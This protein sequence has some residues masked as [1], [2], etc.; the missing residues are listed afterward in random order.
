MELGEGG[1]E[2]R[3]KRGGR[4]RHIR[5]VLGS[6]KAQV[7]LAGRGVETARGAGKPVS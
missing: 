6:K 5:K 1:K 7:C 3:M 2:A 4:G